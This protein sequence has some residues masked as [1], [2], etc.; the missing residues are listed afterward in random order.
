MKKFIFLTFL[1]FIALPVQAASVNA[2]DLVP[3]DLIRGSAHNAVYYYAQDGMRYVFPNEKTYHTWYPDFSQVKWISDADLATVQI[4]G[5][6][7]YKPGVKLIKIISSPVVYAVSAHEQLRAV[8]SEQLAKE[9]YGEQWNTWVDDVPDEFFSNYQVEAPLD[10]ASTY[11]PKAETADAYSV[12][13][14][15]QIK[16]FVSV[17]ITDSGYELPTTTVAHHTAVR[18]VN[19]SSQSATASEW[20]SVWGTGTLKP[21]EHFTR[22]FKEDAMGRWNFYNKYKSKETMQGTLVVE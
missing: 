14:Q 7:T 11:N 20:D 22:Y 5:N 15:K 8:A 17:S 2:T 9:L 1:A 19:N 4:G 16:P 13:N 6:V 3:G 21:G 10:V 18:F 12:Q